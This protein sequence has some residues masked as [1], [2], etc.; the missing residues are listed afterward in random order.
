MINHKMKWVQFDNYIT[1]LHKVFIEDYI[2]PTVSISN[3]GSGTMTQRFAP[4][5][6][7]TENTSLIKALISRN[8]VV[9][10]SGAVFDTI[11]MPNNVRRLGE[12][13][14]LHLVVI[15]NLNFDIHQD[16][17]YND[18]TFADSKESKMPDDLDF[19][20]RITILE[21]GREVL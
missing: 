1:C 13:A 4:F 7:E 17:V 11:P 15:N 9:R 20:Q 19:D 14:F 8:K 3:K 18:A 16:L 12:N 6:E 21:F 2:L 5:L 10:T